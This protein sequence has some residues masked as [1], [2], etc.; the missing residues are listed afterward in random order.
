MIKWNASNHLQPG[1]GLSRCRK[2]IYRFCFDLLTFMSWG[3]GAIWLCQTNVLGSKWKEIFTLYAAQSM[4][5]I[6]IVD[7]GPQTLTF[8]SIFR[9]IVHILFLPFR[10]FYCYCGQTSLKNV[11]DGL[12]ARTKTIHSNTGFDGQL[13]TVTKFF[14]MFA[15]SLHLSC[16]AKKWLMKISTES[17]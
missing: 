4:L 9:I 2:L 1:I 10:L 11:A 8:W 14:K 12:N 13:H 3:T 7:V 15:S 5:T 6:K 17:H 16:L